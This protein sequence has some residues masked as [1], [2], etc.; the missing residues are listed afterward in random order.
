MRPRNPIQY[1]ITVERREVKQKLI[2]S[3]GTIFNLK[4]E[5]EKLLSHTIGKPGNSS[6]ETVSKFYTTKTNEQQLQTYDLSGVLLQ[7]I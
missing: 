6:L 5:K 2:S 4:P 3:F 7:T 1:E